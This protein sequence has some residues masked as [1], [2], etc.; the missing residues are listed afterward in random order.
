M[1]A[2]MN[3]YISRNIIVDEMP[4]NRIDKLLPISLDAF[5]L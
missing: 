4:V 3:G 5:V 1:M 2:F